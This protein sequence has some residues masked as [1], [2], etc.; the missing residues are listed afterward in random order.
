MAS[1]D[2][3]NDGTLA[4]AA[5]KADIRNGLADLAEGRMQDFDVVRIIER[6]KKLLAGRSIVTHSGD[7]L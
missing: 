4:L 3:V 6:G 1:D 2:I 5:L 7:W